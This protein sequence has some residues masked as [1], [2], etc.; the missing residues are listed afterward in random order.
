MSP[1]HAL[2]QKISYRNLLLFSLPTFL[3]NLF[4]SIYGIV[5]GFFASN[6]IGTD[7]L[8][9]ITIT[10]PVLMLTMLIGTMFGAG[11]NALV[12]R[13]LGEGREREAKEDFTLL[14]IAGFILTVVL[15]VLIYL[16]RYPLAAFF[17]ADAG[18]IPGCVE[19]MI[20]LL[21][22]MPLNY[23]GILLEMFIITVGKPNLGLAASVAGGIVNMFLDW[24]FIVHFGWGLTGASLATGIGYTVPGVLGI[25][26]FAFNRN[27]VLYFVRPKWR[28]RT[29][30]K[31]CANGASEMVGMLAGS[32][33]MIVVNNVIMR[34]SGSDG[35]AAVAVVLYAQ[36]M[37]IALI[38]GY[39]RG[40]SPLVSYNQGKMDISKLKSSYRV[41]LVTSFA[42]SAA[43]FLICILFAGPLVS[44]FARADAA[45][46]VFDMATHGF[47][48]FAIS[49]LFS[50]LN[51]MTSAL[52]TALNDGKTSAILSFCHTFIFILIPIVTLPFLFGMEGVWFS[53]PVSEILSFAM[54][55][56]YIGKLRNNPSWI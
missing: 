35:V 21:L 28:L 29:L 27:Q 47:G 43:G 53:L 44:I 36:S 48:I 18:L 42:F 49:L 10:M 46:S 6:F 9:A 5:D 51:I 56:Y 19:Y 30:T 4:M 16:I 33:T 50:G 39:S 20:P 52:F 25:I 55:A 2:E 8:S 38:D 40:V 1:D 32:V 3:A 15:C 12:A 22:L 17:G 31:S 11:G 13:K 14:M 24:L 41:T 37:F 34:V 26:W 54:T 23:P 7:A 45:K